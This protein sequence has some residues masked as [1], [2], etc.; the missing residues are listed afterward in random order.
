MREV[1]KKLESIMASELNAID[2]QSVSSNKKVIRWQNTAKWERYN[3]V[4]EGLLAN[5][6]PKGI[7]EITSAGRMMLETTLKDS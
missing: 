3:M 4:Q 5:N 7:W 2:W 1:I 6:S